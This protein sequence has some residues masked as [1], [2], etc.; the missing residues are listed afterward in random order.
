MIVCASMCVCMLNEQSRTP[1][2]QVLIC[3]VVNMYENLF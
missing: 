2:N 1:V 3:L